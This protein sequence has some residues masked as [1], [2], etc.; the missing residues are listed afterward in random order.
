MA[1]HKQPAISYET[2]EQRAPTGWAL[3]CRVR[4]PSARIKPHRH[5]NWKH[6]R[7]SKRGRAEL[8]ELREVIRNLNALMRGRAMPHPSGK[9][10]PGWLLYPYVQLSPPAELSGGG[11]P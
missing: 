10:A 6:G 3:H 9:P 1:S 5:G 7:R 11:Q 8:K 2:N 4:D